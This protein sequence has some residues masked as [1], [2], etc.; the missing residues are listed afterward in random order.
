VERLVPGGERD[1]VGQAELTG[2]LLRATPAVW[3][4]PGEDPAYWTDALSAVLG[5]P[6]LVESSGP[7]RQRVR[8]SRSTGK[9]K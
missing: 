1:L 8:D 3:D 4:T 6:V 5:A 2:R 7:D 9:S